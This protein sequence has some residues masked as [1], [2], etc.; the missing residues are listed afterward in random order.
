MSFVVEALGA[1][2]E[3]GT[4]LGAACGAVANFTLGRRWMFR[5]DGGPGRGASAQAARYALVSLTSLLCNAL[6]EYVLHERAGMQYQLARVAVSVLVSVL[7]NFP[8]QRHFVF[9]TDPLVPW[10]TPPNP[11]VPWGTPPNPQVPW[12]TPPNPQVGSR[13]TPPSPRP[14]ATPSPP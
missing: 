9:G 6:G 12:G 10:G 14:R 2:A 7:W 4:V 11:Q 5:R 8:M 13:A 1:N 3:L